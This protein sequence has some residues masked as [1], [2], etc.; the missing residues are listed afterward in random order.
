MDTGTSRDPVNRRVDLPIHGGFG[1]QPGIDL[2]DQERI[3]DILEDPAPLRAD[4]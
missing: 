2:E 1:L 3:A 4:D